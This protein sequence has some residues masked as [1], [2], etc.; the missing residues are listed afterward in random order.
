M[1]GDALCALFRLKNGYVFVQYLDDDP[2]CDFDYTIY[3]NEFSDIDG[4][5]I[6]EG[7]YDVWDLKRAAEE[8]VGKGMIIGGIDY[9][10]LR[11]F[12]DQC[13]VYME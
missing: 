10:K 11:A 13:M 3:D 1:A 9:N 8:V 5:V 6:G 12:C 7:V 2:D 4:G